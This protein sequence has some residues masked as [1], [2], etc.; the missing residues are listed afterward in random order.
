MTQ[1]P[2]DSRG[3]AEIAELRDLVHALAAQVDGL[4]RENAALRAENQQLKDE[5]ARLKRLPPRLPFAPSGMEKASAAP[6]STPAQPRRRGAKPDR[7]TREV[8]PRVK[9]EGRLSGRPRRRA[10][11]SKA[12][13]PCSCAT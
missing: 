9:P 7:A 8:I 10:P 3:T 1:R 13:P 4:T 2:D 12:T 11:A 6:P 5:I